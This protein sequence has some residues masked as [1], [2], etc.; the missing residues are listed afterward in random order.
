M[1]TPYGDFKD[2]WLNLATNLLTAKR[3]DLRMWYRTP[4]AWY[5]TITLYR[6]KKGVR[7]Y[8]HKQLTLRTMVS[9]LWSGRD[10]LVLTWRCASQLHS[11]TILPPLIKEILVF[12]GQKVGWAPQLARTLRRRQNSLPQSRA[13]SNSLATQHV[14]WSL[15][16]LGYPGSQIYY[17]LHTNMCLW[18]MH[19]ATIRKQYPLSKF[20]QVVVVLTCIWLSRLM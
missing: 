7:C 17:A 8:C 4:R 19:T 20:T 9:Y 2:M 12:P 11:L 5:W 6:H 18:I 13:D 10:F 15:Y 3:S 14:G 16:W 1:Q